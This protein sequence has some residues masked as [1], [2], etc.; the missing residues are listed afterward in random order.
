MR[1]VLTV[2][3][4]TDRLR[5]RLT[6]AESA[7]NSLQQQLDQ[8]RV[9]TPGAR[10]TPAA[11]P[12]VAVAG[13]DRALLQQIEDD[14]AGLRG[15]QPKRDVTLRFLDQQA[16]QSVLVNRF[17][18]DYLSSEREADQKLLARL[19]L[20]GPNDDV[21]Q[22][23][24]DILQEQVIGVYNEDDKVMYLVSASSQFGPTEKDS[25]AHEFTHALQDQYF[26]L[27]KLA[28][29]HPINDDRAL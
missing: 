14:V 4:D 15:L 11:V 17:N 16:L 25:F 26:D 6:A 29:K 12:T 3:S 13:P 8:L 27:S 10:S 2:Q 1:R 9:A 23:L 5:S 21:S 24:L 18:T 20:V 7:Q 28:P 19:G 22:T